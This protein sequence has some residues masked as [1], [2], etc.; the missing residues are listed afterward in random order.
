[1]SS[2]SATPNLVKKDCD[3]QPRHEHVGL[4][5]SGCQNL[6]NQLVRFTFRT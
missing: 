2:T 3:I 5:H 6:V 4:G 1:M